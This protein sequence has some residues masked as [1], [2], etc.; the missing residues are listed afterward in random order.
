MTPLGARSTSVGESREENPKPRA[1]HGWGDRWLEPQQPKAGGAELSR[2]AVAAVHGTYGDRA[3]L[4]GRGLSPA[5]TRGARSVA[6]L[7]WPPSPSSW[8]GV[9]L[10]AGVGAWGGSVGYVHVSIC[11]LIH[12]RWRSHAPGPQLCCSGQAERGAAQ[13]EVKAAVPFPLPELRQ[14]A[15]SE[16]EPEITLLK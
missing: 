10:D 12:P 3:R 5:M 7:R 8:N 16:S 14:Y 4:V 15:K 11:V 6:W 13:E 2:P 1:A 9:P